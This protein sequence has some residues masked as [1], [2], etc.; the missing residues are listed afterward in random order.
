MADIE[1]VA[2][3][4][5]VVNHGSIIWDDEVAA[6]R[7]TLLAT[8]RIDVGLSEPVV[9]FDVPGVVVVDH[10]S[11][12]LRLEVDTAR[13]SVRDALDAV[14]ARCRVSDISVLDPPLEQVI[15]EIYGA[16]RP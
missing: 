8:K 5:V 3:R 7:R 10:T 1:Q 16:A 14:L 13:C 12:T 4:A 6:M 15:G 9:G 11:T 2:Q